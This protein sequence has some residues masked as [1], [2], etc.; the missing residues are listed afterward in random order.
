MM[1]T[2]GNAMGSEHRDKGVDV[3]LG[4]VGE[5][6]RTQSICPLEPRRLAAWRAC[7]DTSVFQCKDQCA[8]FVNSRPNW[9][10]T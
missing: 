5:Y 4:P 3:Q 1:K 6:I 7:S 8:D 9:Q 10:S 2:R